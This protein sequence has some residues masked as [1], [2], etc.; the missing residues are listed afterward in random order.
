MQAAAETEAMVATLTRR[1]M[2]HFNKKHHQFLVTYGWE[3][4]ARVA[5]RS[6]AV[7]RRLRPGKRKP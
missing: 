3:H 1:L 6:P 4:V 5:L 2:R 7:R